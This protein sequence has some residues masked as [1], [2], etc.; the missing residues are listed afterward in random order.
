[1][2]I[3][4]T[5]AKFVA[6]WL[7]MQLGQWHETTVCLDRERTKVDIFM[8]LYTESNTNYQ[9]YNLFILQWMFFILAL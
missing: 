3:S 6:E 1:M 5:I 9:S 7:E 8:S 4:A 2:M